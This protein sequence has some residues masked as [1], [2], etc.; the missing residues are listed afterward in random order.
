MKAW[1]SLLGVV[2]ARIHDLGELFNLLEDHSVTA[3]S[4]FRHLEGLTP[5]AVQF[6]YDEFS[7]FGEEL[8]RTELIAQV[9]DLISHV[10][11][12][13]RPAHGAGEMA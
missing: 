10:S 6:R 11:T 5:F 9:K 2:Y 7:N 13:I 4:G 1:L 3:A 12:L 8:D